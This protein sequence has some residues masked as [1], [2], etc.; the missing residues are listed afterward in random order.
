[1]Q[2]TVWIELRFSSWFSWNPFYM[3]NENENERFE[4]VFVIVIVFVLVRNLPIDIN[5]ERDTNFQTW[6]VFFIPTYLSASREFHGDTGTFGLWNRVKVF[7]QPTSV[8]ESERDSSI[9]ILPPS[10]QLNE[11]P[12]RQKDELSCHSVNIDLE[13]R[14]ASP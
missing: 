12:E 8:R 13:Q 1:M 2:I 3:H 9:V 6:L 5:I 14:I 7:R 10:I 4:D 11:C